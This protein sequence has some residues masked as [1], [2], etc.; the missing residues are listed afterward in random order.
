MLEEKR[1]KNVVFEGRIATGD[2]LKKVGPKTDNDRQKVGA[3]AVTPLR[4]VE[5]G[6]ELLLPYRFQG[7]IMRNQTENNDH[8]TEQMPA[9]ALNRAAIRPAASGLPG[10]YPTYPTGSNISVASGFDEENQLQEHAPSDIAASGQLSTSGLAEQANTVGLVRARPV[11]DEHLQDRQ[12]AEPVPA[13]EQQQ[14]GGDHSQSQPTEDKDHSFLRLLLLLAFCVSFLVV[15]GLIIFSFGGDKATSESSN[16]PVQAE[17]VVGVD[18][19]NNAT[20]P[21]A[22]WTWDLPFAVPNHTIHTIQRDTEHA[23]KGVPMAERTPAAC[24]LFE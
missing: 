17:Q 9:T 21:A 24:Q 2:D 10:A 22:E 6:D 14:Q 20:A 16:L 13:V 1:A 8:P 7:T 5:S 4:A 3:V 18:P 12:T 11:S 19:S 15:I 23:N